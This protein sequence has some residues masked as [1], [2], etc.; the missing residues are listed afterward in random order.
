MG[1]AWQGIHRY[2]AGCLVAFPCPIRNAWVL[3]RMPFAQHR[4][5][6]RKTLTVIM[7]DA[8]GTQWGK[9]LGLDLLEQD[10]FKPV[11][12]SVGTTKRLAATSE[13]SFVSQAPSSVMSEVTS[14]CCLESLA[15]LAL[16]TLCNLLSSQHISTWRGF[17]SPADNR[18]GPHGCC[19]QHLH[20]QGPRCLALRCPLA[21]YLATVLAAAGPNQPGAKMA[22]P[23]EAL[24]QPP[25]LG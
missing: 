24:P 13:E 6:S 7:N 14:P 16:L 11:D 12:A 25:H 18:D 9:D 17:R 8:T 4:P 23:C 15:L 22:L 2:I 5:V 21:R 19:L 20:L 10:G 1:R 3:S